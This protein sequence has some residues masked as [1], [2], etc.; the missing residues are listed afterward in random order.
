[1]IISYQQQQTPISIL[2][3]NSGMDNADEQYISIAER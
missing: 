1:M 3:L 2:L